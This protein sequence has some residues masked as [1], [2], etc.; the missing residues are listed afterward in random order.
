MNIQNF[1]TPYVEQAVCGPHH[2]YY[3]KYTLLLIHNYQTYRQHLTP[4]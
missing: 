1:G 2:P 4:F 3:E